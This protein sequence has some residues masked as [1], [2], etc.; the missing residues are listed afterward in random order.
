MTVLSE[1]MVIGTV[2][3]YGDQALL[4]Q[5]DSTAEVLAWS[6]VLRGADPDDAREAKV[7]VDLDDDPHR[8]RRERDMRTL[9]EHLARLRVEPPGRQ[10]PVDALHVD[11]GAA[12]LAA[13]FDRGAARVANGTGRH[14]RQP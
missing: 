5:F 10:V 9:A 1:S 13:R 6:D 2:T 3:D 14:P 7:D 4:L 8:A 11:L 12:G